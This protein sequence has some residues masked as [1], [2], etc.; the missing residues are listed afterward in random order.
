MSKYQRRGRDIDADGLVDSARRSGVS[1]MKTAMAKMGNWCAT[2]VGSGALR[3]VAPWRFALAPQAT[4]SM[5]LL[6][7]TVFTPS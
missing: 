6:A 5:T 4:P 3:T 1:A 7:P 2:T